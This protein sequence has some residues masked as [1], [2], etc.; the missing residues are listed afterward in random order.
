MSDPVSARVHFTPQ[1]IYEW[2]H[3]VELQLSCTPG[4][5]TEYGWTSPMHPGRQ[6]LDRRANATCSCLSWP[7][8]T[9]MWPVVEAGEVNV[10]KRVGS[11]KVLYIK[12]GRGRLHWYWILSSTGSFFWPWKPVWLLPLQ[13][14]ENHLGPL[15]TLLCCERRREETWGGLREGSKP[16]RFQSWKERGPSFLLPTGG[17]PSREEQKP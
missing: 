5:G 6:C 14:Q 15:A 12:M 16:I 8:L 7:W 11:K 9:D 13:S 1:I 4:S 10:Q 17:R 3:H 2:I